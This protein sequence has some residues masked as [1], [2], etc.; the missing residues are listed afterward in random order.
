MCINPSEI[1][2]KHLTWKYP[3]H[4]CGNVPL[5]IIDENK[6]QVPGAVPDKIAV[7]PNCGYEVGLWVLEGRMRM[8]YGGPSR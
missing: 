5:E 6:N 2:E 4:V 8:Y 3:C 7:C 1:A